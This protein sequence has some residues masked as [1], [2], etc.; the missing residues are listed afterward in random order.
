MKY[1]VL[2]SSGQIGAPLCE[3]LR[4]TGNKVYTYDIEDDEVGQDLRLRHKLRD[5]ISFHSP[6]FVFFLAFDV[7]GSRYLKVY[8]DTSEFLNNN[9][10]IMLHT[11]KALEKTKIPFIFA[12][13]QMSNMSHSS[14]GILKALGEYYTKILNGLTV[15]FW[16]VYGV[17]KDL[18]KA[19]VITDFILKAKNSGVIDSLTDGEELRQF[20]HTDDSSNALYILS[21]KFDEIEKDKNYHIT[22]FHWT[23]I[24]E[25]ANTI[26]EFYPG[27]QIQFV[28]VKDNVQKGMMNH[29]DSFILKYWQPKILL[30]EGIG[31]IIKYY[32]EKNER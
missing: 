26:S 13:S 29:P 5:F 14:Y 32:E 2:G 24:K 3:Y 31:K 27:T 22:S 6:D 18:D 15:K 12:S 30:P 17:E 10:E 28:D 19:H 25:V 23:T 20:L 4:S 16:N 1:L 11:F 7:G 21:Q 9:V 8:Q